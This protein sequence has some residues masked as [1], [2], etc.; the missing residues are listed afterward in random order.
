LLLVDL[1]DRRSYPANSGFVL[2]VVALLLLLAAQLLLVLLVVDDMAG[3][4][5]SRVSLLVVGV[6]SWVLGVAE[7]CV[8]HYLLVC[9]TCAPPVH[10]LC[11]TC[12]PLVHHLCTTCA[13]PVHHPCTTCAP[14]VH[15][16]CTTFVPFTFLIQFFQLG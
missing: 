10:H 8:F 9:T 3:C 5:V 1:I 12:A 15:H 16:L 6:V 13:P 2:V 11:T 7:C 14:P 4:R